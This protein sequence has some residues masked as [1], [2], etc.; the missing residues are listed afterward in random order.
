MI[1]TERDILDN[2]DL[3]IHHH[4]G[5]GDHFI[6][7]GLVNYICSNIEEEAEKCLQS[8]PLVYLA[9]K[10]RNLETVSYLYRE[11]KIVIPIE[12]GDNEIEHVN[13]IVKENDL[14]LIRIGFDKCDIDNFEES[15]YDQLNIPYDIRYQYFKLPKTKFWKTLEIPNEKYI[16]IHDNCSDARYD[17]IIDGSMTKIYF[18]KTEPIFAYID[19]IK[20]ATEIH[21]INSSVY[22]LIDSMADISYPQLFF[23]DVRRTSV[24]CKISKKWTIV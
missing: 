19:L 8:S 24:P 22:H 17:L 11:N 4:L 9:C 21:C 10:K 13:S 20:E 23:H 5:T 1:I 14:K 12:I 3:I 6:C 15:F 18:D 2:R 16:L 7:N